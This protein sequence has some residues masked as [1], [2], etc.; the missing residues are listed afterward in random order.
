M[1]M[2]FK[3]KQLIKLEPVPTYQLPLGSTLQSP[4]KVHPIDSYLE[5]PEI[6]KTS[7]RSNEGGVSIDSPTRLP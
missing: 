2:T 3:P 6:L 4:R 1:Q 7:P 5:I